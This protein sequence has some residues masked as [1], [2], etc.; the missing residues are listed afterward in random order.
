M[1]H[2]RLYEFTIRWCSPAAVKIRRESGG[3]FGGMAATTNHLERMR[4][5]GFTV[6]SRRRG[7]GGSAPPPP[8]SLQQAAQLRPNTDF[9]Y[10]TSGVNNGATALATLENRLDHAIAELRESATFV[11]ELIRIL[12]AS[13]AFSEMLCLGIGRFAS[14]RAARYQLALTLILRQEVLAD[15][16]VLHVFDPVLEDVELELLR[17]RGCCMRPWNEE[18]RV[19][20]TGR[21]LSYLPHC[22]QELYSNLL[23]A[24]WSA[25]KL[26]L[27]FVLGNSFAAL[28]DAPPN[29]ERERIA[30]WCRV[31]RAAPFVV[32]RSCDALGTHD[33]AACDHA[34]GN[35]ALH[36][37][38]A[39]S[40]PPAGDV[41]WT[42][43]FEP[44]P[45]SEVLEPLVRQ[46]QDGC[47][48]CA[49][50]SHG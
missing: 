45:R 11:A 30:S 34:F 27:V 18:G 8:S 29:A 23:G 26:P 37:F 21:C 35:T 3:R 48:C 36:T 25:D 44:W 12:R 4:D 10:R 41:L 22:T 20:V 2:P 17:R 28:V 19:A 24:N 9:R 7:R 49:E 1:C 32:E 43:P 42:R 6:V 16:G 13:G 47:A 46:D 15:E 14:N 39:S 40:M 38:E 5:G 33:H 50:A 31:T